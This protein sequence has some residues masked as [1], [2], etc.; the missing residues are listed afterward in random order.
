MNENWVE[1]GVIHPCSML[2]L[3]LKNSYEVSH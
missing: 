2:L 1:G 3:L